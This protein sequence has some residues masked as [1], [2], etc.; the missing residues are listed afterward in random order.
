M[1]K[2]QEKKHSL[3]VGSA[4]LCKCQLFHI[5]V[6]VVVAIVATCDSVYSPAHTITTQFSMLNILIYF[7]AVMMMLMWKYVQWKQ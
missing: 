7:M 6:V 4:H 3:N 2:D 1:Q 5:I